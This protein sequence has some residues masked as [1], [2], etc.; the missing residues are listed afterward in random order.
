M[1]TSSTI[2]LNS[3]HKNKLK[4]PI[5]NPLMIRAHL[6]ADEWLLSFQIS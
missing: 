4:E 1:N 2:P 6:H 3:K 5:D